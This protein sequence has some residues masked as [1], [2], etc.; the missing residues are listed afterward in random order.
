[1]RIPLLLLHG[2]KDKDVPVMHSEAL[3]NNYGSTD[4]TLLKIDQGLEK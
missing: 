3:Y 1:M 2:I 4:K